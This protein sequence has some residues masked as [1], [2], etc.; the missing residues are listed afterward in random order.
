MN[1]EA[2][3]IPLFT[4]E[5]VEQQTLAVNPYISVIEES[6]PISSQASTD[7]KEVSLEKVS[8]IKS[9]DEIF[10]EQQYEKKLRKAKQI[11]GPT[12]AEYTADQLRDLITEIQ[13]LCDSW[14]DDFERKVFNG[15]TL[16]QLI[17]EKG[18]V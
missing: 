12:A 6:I 2:G 4:V 8:L 18:G 15:L 14:L 16:S 5:E 17:H 10:P 13:F 3:R 9:L 7:E 11:L 1:G